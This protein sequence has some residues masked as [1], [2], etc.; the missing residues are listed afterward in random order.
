MALCFNSMSIFNSIFNGSNE[1]KKLN[2]RID[3]A[4]DSPEGI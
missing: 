4:K 2:I 1:D 3:N